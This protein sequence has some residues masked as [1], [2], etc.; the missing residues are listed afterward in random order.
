[1]SLLSASDLMGMV[2][3]Q[4]MFCQEQ[5]VF[6]DKVEETDSLSVRFNKIRKNYESKNRL[7]DAGFSTWDRF[8]SDLAYLLQ[9][10]FSPIEKFIF[11]DLRCNG[12]APYPQLPVAG[13][14]LDF[15]IL[16]NKIAIECDGA[17]FHDIKKDRERDAKLIALGWRIVR[18]P[19]WACQTPE[20]SFGYIDTVRGVMRLDRGLPQYRE[21][22]AA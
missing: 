10:C 6:F 22:I 11:N 20:R 18:I 4:I 9:D 16:P 17:E 1:M 2:V 8:D 21:E 15:A 14:F 7:V 3:K 19:G 12:I 5:G 13:F